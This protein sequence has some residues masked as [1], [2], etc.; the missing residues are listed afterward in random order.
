MIVCLSPNLSSMVSWKNLALLAIHR[1]GHLL[2]RADSLEKTLMLGKTEGRRSRWPRM[3]WLDGITDSMDMN[4]SKL[5]EI[6]KNREVW[7]AVIQ[8]HRELNITERQN[9]KCMGRCKHMGSQKSSLWCAPQLS[10]TSHPESLILSLW[11]V[12]LPGRMGVGHPVSILGSLKAHPP[13]VADGCNILCLLIQWVA[14][15]FHRR[16]ISTRD[17]EF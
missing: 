5:W 8:G 4:L 14:F 11:E 6:V 3:R 16:T 1:Y 17:R 15:S 10:G 7:H 9:N 13:I 2:Q 12:A